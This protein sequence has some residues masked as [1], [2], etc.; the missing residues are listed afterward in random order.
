MP[1]DRGHDLRPRVISAP[2]QASVVGA[3]TVTPGRPSVSTPNTTA[4]TPRTAAGN[5]IRRGSGTAGPATDRMRGHA[6]LPD[7]T[8]T[9]RR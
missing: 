4:G 1:P 2:A 7:R 9:R 5:H 8:A 3:G 6:Y